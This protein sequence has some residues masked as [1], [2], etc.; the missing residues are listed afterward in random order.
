MADYQSG[1][2]KNTPCAPRDP[3]ACLARVMMLDSLT[4]SEMCLCITHCCSS[5]LGGR[6][7]PP[8]LV[9]SVLGLGRSSRPGSP[10]SPSEQKGFRPLFP[11]AEDKRRGEDGRTVVQ[12][13]SSW[14][15]LREEQR[16]V[17][18]TTTAFHHHGAAASEPAMECQ[19][20]ER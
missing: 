2:G 10:S 5:Q 13:L 20:G 17:Q 1:E 19:D 12:D 9:L 6:A 11:R 4:L 7:E 8:D 16:S 3:S 18:R 14:N 15:C